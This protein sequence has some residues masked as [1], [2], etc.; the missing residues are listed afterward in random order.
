MKVNLISVLE[1]NKFLLTVA[2]TLFLS[3]IVYSQDESCSQTGPGSGGWYGWEYG[4]G[5]AEREDVYTCRACVGWPGI[6]TYCAIELQSP[7]VIIQIY[8]ANSGWY[9]YYQ[10]GSCADDIAA[11][12]DD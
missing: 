9:T 4:S 7:I 12:C 3:G 8:N 6:N 11:G 10:G 2:I 5:G 1:T